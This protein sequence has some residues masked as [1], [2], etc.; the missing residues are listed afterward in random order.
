MSQEHLLRLFFD[1]VT[2]STRAPEEHP[3]HLGVLAT[4]WPDGIR[5]AFRAHGWGPDA[6]RRATLQL[7]SLWRGLQIEL[8]TGA[9]VAALDDAHDTAV[10]ALFST[11]QR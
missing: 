8:L 1:L 5:S 9:D 6:A 3:M 10:A 4:H 7:L 2:L 11:P